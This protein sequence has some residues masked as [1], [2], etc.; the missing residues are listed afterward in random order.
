MSKRGRK[1]KPTALK[2]L[3]GNPGRRP[4][5][6]DEPQP[7][8]LTAMPRAPDFLDKEGRKFWKQIGSELIDCGI[9]TKLDLSMFGMLCY[10]YE[11]WIETHCRL[12]E[13]GL[14]YTT[15]SGIERPHPLW[16]IGIDEGDRFL[17]LAKEFGLT[18]SSRSGLRVVPK[19]KPDALDNLF[20]LMD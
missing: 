12:E 17:R 9:L 1:P 7:N 14:I 18:P 11:S 13:S 3:Q 19:S 2:R 10:A 15:P 6:E 8:E 20:K 16:K 5:P 4:L